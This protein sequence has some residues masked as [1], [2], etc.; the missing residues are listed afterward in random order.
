M[1]FFAL[2]AALFAGYGTA[3]LASEDIRYLTRAGFEETRI[4]QSRQP[5]ARLIQDSS[6]SPA[7]RQTLHLVVQ[8]RDYAARLGLKAKETYTTYSDV[9]R[10]TLLLVLQ[11]APKDCICPYTWKYPIVGRI[12]YKGFFD[13]RAARR[14][15]GL[16]V[17]FQRWAGSKILCFLLP[18]RAIQ[19]ILL[20]RCFTRS[21]TIR[22]T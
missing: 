3:Y 16:R 21:R 15:A 10:D 14:E 2:V 19:W 4:L 6:T 12:P 13:A 7:L 18:L 20:R 22:F 9:G 8:T 17:R 11:A 1:V 5:I